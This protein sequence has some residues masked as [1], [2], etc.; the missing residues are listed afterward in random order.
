MAKNNYENEE[1]E[2]SEV[3]MQEDEMSSWRDRFEGQAREYFDEM[4]RTGGDLVHPG[5]GCIASVRLDCIHSY[6]VFK[7]RHNKKVFIEM[8]QNVSDACQTAK[9]LAYCVLDDAV[10]LLVKGNRQESAIAFVDFIIREFTEKYNRGLRSVGNPFRP[11]YAVRIIPHDNIGNELNRIHSFAPDGMAASYPFC[12]YKYLRSGEH[13]ANLILK[14]EIDPSR[15]DFES[16]IQGMDGMSVSTPKGPEGYKKVKGE[17]DK[18][19]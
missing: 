16:I 6:S 3:E 8:L 19:F 11:D 10:Y 5:K 14:L 7:R 12:S 9:I 4:E 15:E 13:D 17:M 2:N 18:K 1:I